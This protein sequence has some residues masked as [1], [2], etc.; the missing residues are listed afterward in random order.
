LYGRVFGHPNYRDGE[1]IYVSTP[2][3][4]VNKNTIKTCSG[5]TYVL[6]HPASKMDEIHREI[7]AVI[8]RGGY[9][10]H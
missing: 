2:T 9:S 5:R 7:D 1:H 3:A 8:E 10:K 4:W 6:M